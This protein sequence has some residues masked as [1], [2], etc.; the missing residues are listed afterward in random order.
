MLFFYNDKYIDI[1]ILVCVAASN[2][3]ADKHGFG[4]WNVAQYLGCAF[5]NAYF[6]L[7]ESYLLLPAVYGV[8]PTDSMVESVGAGDRVWEVSF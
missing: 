3:V 6:F 4:K 5:G 7:Y 1:A 8:L 2:G